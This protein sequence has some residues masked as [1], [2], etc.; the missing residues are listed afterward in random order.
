MPAVSSLSSPYLINQV[1]ISLFSA[2]MRCKKSSTVQLLIFYSHS[3]RLFFNLLMKSTFQIMFFVK[4]SDFHDSHYNHRLVLCFF[5]WS[6]L[7]FSLCNVSFPFSG[8]HLFQSDLF[9]L[10]IQRYHD[11]VTISSVT[12]SWRASW[13]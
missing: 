11:I 8:L 12:K 4:F 6:F 10:K 9:Y 3:H 13:G 5:V 1:M 2:T 7:H